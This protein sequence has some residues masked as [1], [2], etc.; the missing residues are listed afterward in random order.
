MLHSFFKL[1]NKHYKFSSHFTNEL[2]F[3]TN[4]NLL[5]KKKLSKLNESQFLFILGKLLRYPIDQIETNTLNYFFFH[6]ETQKPEEFALPWLDQETIAISDERFIPETYVELNCK[7]GLESLVDHYIN[8]KE[9]GK[10][11]HINKLLVLLD[12]IYNDILQPVNL[13]N[14]SFYD[15]ID[16]LED[17]TDMK[18]FIYLND[19]RIALDNYADMAQQLCDKINIKI[20][21]LSK[22]NVSNENFRLE[23]DSNILKKIYFGLEQQMFINQEKTTCEQ[24][25]NVLQLDWK[26]HNSI[27]TFEMDHILFKH[28]IDFLDLY[29]NLKIQLSTIEY[30]AKIANKNGLIKASRV[31]ASIGQ[32]RKFMKDRDDINALKSMFEKIKNY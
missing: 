15:Y 18:R 6:L 10:D 30:S 1:K 3:Y 13:N 16:N 31:S 20:T 21:L 17:I 5:T 2:T 32:Y 23:I 19:I 7:K 8:T 12:Y 14:Y 4:K 27:I 24:F 11:T 28:F 22:P 29:F 26:D 25:L 9:Y